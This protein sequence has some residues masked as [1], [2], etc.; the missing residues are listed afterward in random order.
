MMTSL[1]GIGDGWQE[2]ELNNRQRGLFPEA[3]RPL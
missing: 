3:Y 1:W 2:G